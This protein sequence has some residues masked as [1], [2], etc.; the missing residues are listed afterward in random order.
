MRTE[1]FRE[2]TGLKV[3]TL[4][5]ELGIA[6][7]SFKRWRG[8][9]PLRQK[10]GPKKYLP[11]P[12][13]ALKEEIHNLKH[14]R[15]RS[16][17]TFEIYQKYRDSISRRELMHMI[18]QER[19]R[20]NAVRSGFQQRLQW[21]E[22]G[23]CWSIDGT[24]YGKDQQ[25][26]SLTVCPVRD[27]SSKYEFEPHTG[28]STQGKDVAMH[29]RELFEKYGPPLF[30]KRDNGGIFNSQEVEDAMAEYGVLPLN[31]PPYC[32]RYNGARERG[33]RELKEQAGI[34]LQR[35]EPQALAPYMEAVV[36]RLNIKKRKSLRGQ[37][38][39]QAHFLRAQR[40][41]DKKQRHNIFEWM[42]TRSMAIMAQM[43]VVNRRNWD[44]SWRQAAATW[45]S[46]QGLLTIS[47]NNQKCYPFSRS[48]GLIN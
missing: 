6:Y 48:N 31:S 22:P 3:R 28:V 47:F 45:L 1:Q 27:L 8:K 7:G 39:L 40:K 24:E 13:E 34:D 12:F 36:N 2:S 29:L 32:P 35:W 14:C 41:Y 18:Q 30:L 33:I 15:Q 42:K 10:P 21:H 25:G 19:K 23:V 20:K 26:K 5:R 37:C 4:C 16:F 9:T 17:G 44:A 46:D 11:L 38:A 43:G